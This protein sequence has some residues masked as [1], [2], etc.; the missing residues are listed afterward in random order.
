MELPT[1]L[2]EQKAYLFNQIS[3]ILWKKKFKKWY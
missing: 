1:K 3:K 2:L